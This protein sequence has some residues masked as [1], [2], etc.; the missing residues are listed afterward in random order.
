MAFGRLS[1]ARA[2]RATRGCRPRPVPVGG[3]SLCRVPM[4]ERRGRSRREPDHRAR[5]DPQIAVCLDLPDV[6]LRDADLDLR[7]LLGRRSLVLEPRAQLDGGQRTGEDAGFRHGG[8]GPDRCL[9]RTVSGS[10]EPG[11]PDRDRRDTAGVRE[12]VPGWSQPADDD[13]SYG[14]PPRSRAPGTRTRATGG[15]ADGEV[16]AS[17]AFGGVPHTAVS[18]ARPAY[19]CRPAPG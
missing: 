7:P 8:G 11:K 16:P 1:A 4:Q 12:P 14:D 15:P 10:R 2:S 3:Q 18:R 19:A 9:R 6:G 17:V 5:L 13:T